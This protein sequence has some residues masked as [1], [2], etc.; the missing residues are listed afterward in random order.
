MYVKIFRVEGESELIRRNDGDFT[1]SDIELK[2]QFVAGGL[3]VNDL[4]K[5]THKLK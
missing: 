5:L 4:P 2:I 1:F 3:V